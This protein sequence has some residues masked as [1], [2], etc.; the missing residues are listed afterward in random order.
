MKNKYC[1]TKWKNNIWE[2]KECQRKRERE[3]ER[4][5]EVEKQHLRGN[6]LTGGLGE[7]SSEDKYKW[8]LDFPKM[9]PGTY[10]KRRH[11]FSYTSKTKKYS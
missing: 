9:K 10:I 1:Y 7:D 6:H 5:R 2:V 4:E 3:R 11:T 8:L